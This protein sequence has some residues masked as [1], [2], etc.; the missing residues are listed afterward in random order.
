MRST[1]TTQSSPRARKRARGSTRTPV[2]ADLAVHP[3]PHIYGTYS[4]E[5]LVY[6][7]TLPATARN[8]WRNGEEPSC[9]SLVRYDDD[10][11]SI[12]HR[13]AG[14]SFD[15]R[16]QCSASVRPSHRPRAESAALSALETSKGTATP[17]SSRHARDW[18]AE[19]I[20]IKSEPID[21]H[22]LEI[23][24]DIS[25]SSDSSKSKPEGPEP[26]NQTSEDFQASSS[27]MR[28]RSA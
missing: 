26:G 1:A 19:S 6:Y 18:S 25:T 8:L 3:I 28:E 2:E 17:A 20:A 11:V 12:Q 13:E 4:D 22:D 5:E 16:A 27:P 9:R 15:D 7:I 10:E 14:L 23:E 21:D 24:D